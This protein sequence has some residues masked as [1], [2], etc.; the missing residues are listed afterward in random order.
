M[1]MPRLS[2][3]QR[4]YI[5]PWSYNSKGR[6]EC[7]WPMLPPPEDARMPSVWDVTCRCLGTTNRVTLIW[8]AWA[9]TLD[10]G[11]VRPELLPMTIYESVTLQQPG[12]VLKSVVHVATKGPWK[13]GVW[14]KTSGLVE[15]QRLCHLQSH[16]VWC[17]LCSH[18]PKDLVLS[19]PRAPV[20]GHF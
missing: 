15:V 7:P 3:C 5:G 1:A 10:H 6:C 8:L 2:C 19:R 4:P 18:P 16:V 13:P 17:N 12:S 9:A 20:K 11:E 14:A